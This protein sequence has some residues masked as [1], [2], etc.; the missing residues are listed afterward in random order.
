MIEEQAQVIAVSPAGIRVRVER[1]SA[2]GHCQVA[3]TCGYGALERFMLQRD[4]AIEFDLPGQHGF[5]V[6]ESLV[7]GI[8]DRLLITSAALVYLVPLGF[9]FLGLILGA[10]L[11]KLIGSDA[12]WLQIT[13]L[14]A[15][16]TGAFFI[17]PWLVRRS[18][19]YSN[20]LPVVLRRSSAP[21]SVAN[22]CAQF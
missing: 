22:S 10:G 3:S 19:I 5:A 7:I 18:R 20:L 21:S 6:G 8:A 17:A 11:G 13:G 2:C 12:E 1:K 16:G 9:I 15:G 14:V 4:R